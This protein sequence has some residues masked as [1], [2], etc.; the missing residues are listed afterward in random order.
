VAELRMLGPVQLWV[1]G[2]PVDLGPPRQRGMLAA[3]AV[4]PN[5]PVPVPALL[6][7]IWDTPPPAARDVL[8]THLSGLRRTLRRVA[9]ADPEAPVLAR[10]DGGYVLD[11]DPGMTD[12]HRFRRLVKLARQPA[13]PPAEQA[14]LLRQALDL[15]RG[16]VLADLS[17]A[18][19]GRTRHAWLQQ[20]LAAARQWA[21]V[22]LHEGR[23]SA[24]VEE[25]LGLTAE[26]PL[27]E[28]LLALLMRALHA[29]RRD[30]EALDLYAAGRRKLADELGVDPG[31]ELRGVHQAIL[32]GTLPPRPGASTLASDGPNHAK[33]AW[34]APAQL[35]AD[36][37][38]FIG[39]TQELTALDRLSA[40]DQAEGAAGRR[41]AVAISAV[42]G[43]AG[44]GKTALVVHWAHRVRDA[45]P[46]GQLY[47]NLHGYDR[48]QPLSA[49]AALAGFLR[50][51]GVAGDDIPLEVEERAA[52]YRS[53]LAGRRM[54]IVLDNAATVE[55]VRLLLPG[56]PHSVV[57]VTSRDSLIGLIALHGAHRLDLDLLPRSDAVTLLGALIG[58][59]VAAEPGAAAALADQCA[60]LPLAL[61]VAAEL[62][63]AR[64]GNTLS[65]LVAELADQQRRLD[66]L[67]AGDD[68]RAEV[69]GVFSMSYRRLP[70]DAA[71]AFRL[72]GLHPGPDLDTHAAAALIGTGLEHAR[73]LLDLLR[74]GHLVHG[75]GP[76]RC[77]MHDLLR[78]YASDLASTEDDEV[79]S[80]EALTR[81][82]DLYLATAAAAMDTLFPAERQHRPR[83]PPP[84][85]PMPSVAEPAAARAWLTAERPALVAACGYASRHG[86]PAHTVRLARTAFRYLDAGGHHPD[87]LA[88]HTLA[89]DAAGQIGDLTAEAHALTDI[90][91]VHW[92]QGRYTQAGEHL[93]EALALFRAAGERYGEARALSNL[94]LVYRWQGHYAPA[95]DCH[96]R[97]LRVY[98]A[99]DDQA[100]QA[101]ALDNL[102][103]NHRMQG[104]Y[105]EAIDHHSRALALYRE[106]GYRE[107]DFDA[108]NNIGVLYRMQGRYAE[109]A[110]HLEE[111]LAIHQTGGVGEAEAL[112]DL[113][114]I[115]RRQG[116]HDEAVHHHQQALAVFHEI[117]DR[118]GEA[119]ARNGLGESMHTTGRPDEAR[120]Q[121]AAALGLAVET[122]DRY[123]QA[124]AHAGLAQGHYASGQLDR[125][126]RHWCRALALY[127]DLGVP[128]ADD[129]RRH[130]A[131]LDQ[132]RATETSACPGNAGQPNV[133]ELVDQRCDRAGM[134]RRN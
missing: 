84:A 129:V 120:S 93:Q 15:W 91:L 127:T 131:A 109:A 38:V 53:L 102:G 72:L 16:P 105:E 94:G 34:T 79:E 104:R 90:G 103:V 35:P 5:Q 78:A 114:D 119:K 77:G 100:S 48:E 32:R 9:A 125:A 106:V 17:S 122:G 132:P 4:G 64:P 76:G 81:L 82:L 29:D 89:R 8:Y 27:V 20:R 83:V 42:S 36:V 57:V 61:R 22:E 49:A 80:R 28:P 45:F 62:A 112:T 13:A 113:G 69:R 12:A 7:R 66:L 117:A 108:L 86:W 70:A 19:A 1:A 24:V 47:V 26:H 23:P 75:T 96:E 41:S 95:I 6:E 44:V 50:A 18:W 14:A 110:A 134:L 59:R 65:E 115:Y 10:R 133:G 97:A 74:R 107:G 11:I 118:G 21:E 124:R 37:H 111:A 67:D 116:R 30:A 54:L 56:S 87:A 126:R 99:T 51:L 33:P 46:D 123:Q 31:A 98:R 43:T 55:Q 128:E 71:R 60:R 88:V 25:L 130:L 58:G 52:A 63:I 3:L 101:R 92:R 85:T 121:H 68:A 73:R 2:R 40:A 39:R